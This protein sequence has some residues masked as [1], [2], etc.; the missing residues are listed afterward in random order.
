MDPERRLAR[1]AGLSLAWV[2]AATLAV[3]VG[4]V[5]VSQVGAS[6]RGRGPLGNETALT[7][8]LQE[9]SA[10]PLADAEPVR[11]TVEEEFGAFVVECRGA[12]AYGIEARP[13]RAAG[14]RTVSYEPGPDDDVDAVF[15]NQRRSIDLEVFCNRGRPT[16]SELERNTLPDE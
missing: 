3:V 10:V 8:E 11:A 6:I 14:W 5:A 12:V 15:A 16:V 2:V 9:G 4:L 1:R 13:D 7:A